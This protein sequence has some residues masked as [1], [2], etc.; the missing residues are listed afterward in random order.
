MGCLNS[1]SSSGD[2]KPQVD[3][4]K[5]TKISINEGRKQQGK[6]MDGRKETRSKMSQKEYRKKE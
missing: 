6:E 2:A 3:P 4:M 1:T 5:R